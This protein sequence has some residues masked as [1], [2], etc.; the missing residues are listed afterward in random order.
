MPRI[1]IS[2]FVFGVPANTEAEVTSSEV[3]KVFWIALDDLRNPANHGTVEITL[4][5]GPR[6]FP[7]YD[8][9]GEQV[10]GLTHRILESFLQLYL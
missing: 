9:V 7:T 10:W 8:V 6:D 4:P 2:A 1:T 5:T 3:D